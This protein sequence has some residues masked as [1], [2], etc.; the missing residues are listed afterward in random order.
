[1]P[2]SISTHNLL[3]IFFKE[4]KVSKELALLSLL[5]DV[6]K[7]A[8]QAGVTQVINGGVDLAKLLPHLNKARTA[9]QAV[10]VVRIASVGQGTRI[11]AVGVRNVVGAATPLAITTAAKV[12]G[13]LGAAFSVGDAIYSWAT[14]NPTRKSAEALLRDVEKEVEKMKNNRKYLSNL[15]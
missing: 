5:R 10:K 8:A 3:I 1:M 2:S 4:L 14:K 9:V 6:P 13:G 15:V 11:T 12:L 7:A